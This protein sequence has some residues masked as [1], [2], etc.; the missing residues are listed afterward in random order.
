MKTNFELHA[1]GVSYTLVGLKFC[2]HGRKGVGV[3]KVH[4]PTVCISSTRRSVCGGELEPEE[5]IVASK[6]E[7]EKLA[8]D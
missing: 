1:L 5:Q 6:D 8:S 7:L 3:P 2:D 4:L